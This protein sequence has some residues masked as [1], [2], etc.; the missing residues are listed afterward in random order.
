[1][2]VLALAGGVGGAKLAEGLAAIIPPGE[3][4]VSVNTGDDFEHLGLRI[5]PDIDTVTYTLAGLNNQ[6]QGWGLEGETWNFIAALERLGGETWFRLGDRDLATHIERTQRLKS[7][8]LSAVTADFA[9]RLGI[10]QA[11]VPVTDDPLRTMVQTDQGLLAFQDYFVRLRCAPRVDRLEFPGVEAMKPSAGFAAALAD[12]NLRAIVICPSNPFLSI[13]PILSLPGIRDALEGRRVPLLAVSPIIGGQAVKGPAAK[14]M[15]ELGLN[16]SSAGVAG[17]YG[18]LLDG[19]MIDETD[20]ALAPEI[21]GP[22]IHVGDT[23]M[24][25]AGDRRR[26]ATEVLAFAERISRS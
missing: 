24:R 22:A 25:D 12:A 17:F 8:T 2:S 11:I 20:R 4:T 9:K 23:M 3:L 18:A 16:V 13:L 5:S 10:R 1:V 6:E 7:E 26:V 19:L 14:I 15:Q 21:A